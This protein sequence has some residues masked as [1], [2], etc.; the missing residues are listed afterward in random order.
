MGP[1]SQFRVVAIS[2]LPFSVGPCPWC[3]TKT[4]RLQD[5]RLQL[6]E[7]ILLCLL[8]AA[9]LSFF[10]SPWFKGMFGEALVST[11]LRRSLEEDTYRL[12]NDLT[13]PSGAGTT[14]IDHVVL[15]RFGVFVIET[16]NMKGWIYGSPDQVQWTQV[17]YRHKSR[18]QNP[19]HQNYKHIKTIQSLL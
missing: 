11:L 14:Q 16:K 1:R 15:S 8:V 6:F 5:F 7:I 12:L 4:I 17:I 13:L 3:R 19:L 10:R 9:V 18:F 2:K